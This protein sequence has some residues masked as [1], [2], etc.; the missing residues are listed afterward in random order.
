ML[1]ARGET[2][3]GID[4]VD[5]RSLLRCLLDS[6]FTVAGL[7]RVA[8]GIVADGSVLLGV[9]RQIGLV[10]DH[11][12]LQSSFVVHDDH[13]KLDSAELWGLTTSGRA[14]AR[15]RIGVAMPRHHAEELLSGVVERA[16]ATNANPDGFFFVE[17][18]ELFGSLSTQADGP[19]GDVDLRVLISHR[20]NGSDIVKELQRRFGG[21]S[22][23]ALGKATAQLRRHL[24]GGSPRIDLQLDESLPRPLPDG[25]Q[26]VV[27]YQRQTPNCG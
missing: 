9:L 24:T 22:L 23:R 26:P 19:V 25:A 11:A 8:G 1:I 12:N 4:V 15:A 2:V 10:S 6:S 20:L 3:A 13:E 17:T 16:R 21:D 7:S 14:L 5:L 27:V 18:I